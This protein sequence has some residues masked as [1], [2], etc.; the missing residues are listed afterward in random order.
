[1]PSGKSA[2]KAERL[3]NLVIALLNSRAVPRRHLD[4]GQG[5]GLPRRRR[6]TRR[7][8]GCSSATRSNSATSASRCRPPRTAP[9]GSRPVSTRC[10]RCRSPRGRRPRSRWPD[11]S[12]RPVFS[13][14]PGRVRCASWPTP[15][16]T[17]WSFPVVAAAPGPHLR[18]GV[19][20]AVRRG[21]GPPGGHLPVPQ[22]PGRVGRA[23]APAALGSGQLEGSL[24]RRRSRRRPRRA[25]HVPA[26]PDRRRRGPRRPCRRRRHPARRRPAGRRR[27]VAGHP[28]AAERGRPARRRRRRRAA[29]PGHRRSR[30]CGHAA[31]FRAV[32]DPGRPS[33]GHR[34]HG[35]GPR[36]G[37]RR[38]VARRPPGRGDPVAHRRSG[39]RRV[40]APRSSHRWTAS[41]RSSRDQRVRH[42]TAGPG[43]GPGA[44]HLPSARGRH[45]RPR[46]RVRRGRPADPEGPGPAD[47]LRA[48]RLLP[49]RP[50]RRRAVR[51]RRQRCPSP[52][53]PVWSGRCG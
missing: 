3:L 6:T 16:A 1:M 37:R 51:G 34:P 11:G 7:S 48:A 19:R 46:G 15:A 27:R 23:P 25:A 9:T 49:G 22:G 29:P 21:P 43:V 31:G 47:G 53:T 4:P 42:R 5:R 45:R 30:D 36:P 8:S 32:D 24:V 18:P 50:D 12:G 20:T 33:V 17:S 13:V 38:R 26:V 35:R 28:G 44:L 10:P 40:P 41:T 52:S 2:A 39:R 14:R